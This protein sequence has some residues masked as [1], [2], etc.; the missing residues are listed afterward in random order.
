MKFF[1]KYL[2]TLLFLASFNYSFAWYEYWFVCEYSTCKSV[3]EWEVEIDEGWYFLDSVE[4]VTIKNLS[5][6]MDKHIDSFKQAFEN[7]KV[8]LEWYYTWSIIDSWGWDSSDI[9]DKRLTFDQLIE[10]GPFKIAKYDKDDKGNKDDDDKDDDDWTITILDS[11]LDGRDYFYTHFNSL[12][13]KY[14]D[15]SYPQWLRK[16]NLNQLIKNIEY[17]DHDVKQ[18]IFVRM[19][20]WVLCDEGTYRYA[21]K[22]Y[23]S[24]D[25]IT[26]IN[27]NILPFSSFRVQSFD[28][29]DKYS[30]S[31]YDMKAWDSIW[32]KFWFKDHLNSSN[33]T[34]K[35]TYKISYKYD[36]SPLKTLLI[37]D[38]SIR[39]SDFKLTSTW[40]EQEIINDIFTLERSRGKSKKF[41]LYINESVILTKSWK[42]TFYIE[43]KNDTTWESFPTTTI[44]NYTKVTV[45]RNDKITSATF[46][47]EPWE[48]TEAGNNTWY[49]VNNTFGVNMRLY[50]SYWNLHI[51]N[52][53]WYTIRLNTWA[54]WASRDFE[55]AML[56]SDE[57]SSSSISNVKNMDEQWNIKFKF[58]V[59]GYWY[60]EFWWVDVIARTKKTWDPWA[61]E[62][63]FN[64]LSGQIPSWL[65]K[66]STPIK[67]YIKSKFISDLAISCSREIVLKTRCTSDNLSWCDINWN[68]TIIYN[69][70]SQNWTSGTLS[71]TD[72]AFNVVTQNYTMNHVDRTPPNLDF[73][74]NWSKISWE[75]HIKATDK[76]FA[77]I[78]DSSTPTNCND[79]SNIKTN[80]KVKVNWVLK[81]D[82]NQQKIAFNVDLSE[83]SKISWTYNIEI[84]ATDKHW[85]TVSKTIKLVTVPDDTDIPTP[86]I[87]W[88]D[89]VPYADWEQYIEHT[90]TFIDRFGN[91]IY[92]KNIDII[93]DC[94]QTDSNN[95]M[96][97]MDIKTIM[98]WFPTEINRRPN[99]IFI[100]KLTP[101]TDAN[102]QIKFRV[103]SVSPW[104]FTKQYIA[105]IS[106]WN[107]DYTDNWNKEGLIITSSTPKWEFKKIYYGTLKTSKNW[108]TYNDKPEIWTKMYYKLDIIQELQWFTP[109]GW[110]GFD[111]VSYNLLNNYTRATDINIKAE[112][113]SEYT[114][115]STNTYKFDARLNTSKDA[116]ILGKPWIKISSDLDNTSPVIISYK[117]KWKDV[118]YYVSKDTS[119]LTNI[120]IDIT[121]GEDF[122][123]VKVIWQLQRS[124]KSG[125]SIGRDNS[126][127]LSLWSQRTI[128]RKNAMEYVKNMTNWRITWSVKYVVWDVKASEINSGINNDEFETVIIKDGNLIINQNLNPQNKKFGIIVLRDWYDTS[129]D[130]NNKWNIYVA[131]NVKEINAILYADGWMISVDSA[132]KPY[133]TDT[134]SRTNALNKQLTLNWT[135]FTRNTIGWAIFAGWDYMLPWQKSTESFDNAM[136]YDLNYLRRWNSW[137]QTDTDSNCINREP[138]IIRYDASI[139]LN[140]P[141][142]FVN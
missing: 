102:W 131:P 36:G 63:S 2:I 21:W 137:C 16:T 43:V 68:Q 10:L 117:L 14:Y 98:A 61:Y 138:F 116:E 65:I 19:C 11:Y 45:T 62:G 12:T 42:V 15:K 113:V 26:Y 90:L 46:D 79:T 7:K 111:I 33:D 39:Y 94:S 27:W 5:K 76:F 140:P 57:Y 75:I 122:M 28:K 74:I 58:R 107:E 66:N 41:T 13:S 22:S 49:N 141:K 134:T 100:E 84:I 48:F 35:Y 95:E 88:W 50:D 8:K 142:L 87:S 81:K 108:T 83:Y 121:E 133:T 23:S 136:I 9:S 112:S 24:S 91:P 78:D 115:D 52:I 60:H 53:R 4:E 119:W 70:E 29:S 55:L 110:G 106:H 93:K 89:G 96:W 80:Y 132:F 31:S 124:G 123:W 127:D 99:A 92:D 1:F 51:D 71:F 18:F 126:T 109:E 25:S 56:W 82:L 97:C 69:K 85:N 77:T 86:N 3:S 72:K 44:N 38:I 6:E 32:F 120:P 54:T 128:I 105:K 130:Y 139:Q 30:I 114:K 125:I 73:T 118:K 104:E 101:K 59:T 103:K 34:T 20:S 47:F 40:V 64:T 67:V 129:K 135:L 17:Y 37:E